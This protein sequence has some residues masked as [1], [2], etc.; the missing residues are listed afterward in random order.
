M[1]NS[2]ND[3]F[4][5]QNIHIRIQKAFDIYMTYTYGKMNTITLYNHIYNMKADIIGTCEKFQVKLI[6]KFYCIWIYIKKMFLSC[7]MGPTVYMYI[8]MYKCVCVCVCVCAI[9]QNK[10]FF[11]T[12]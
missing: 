10:Y 7:Y 1:F 2:I 4:V 12:D 3:L 5:L 9:A 6:L 11:F 8:C